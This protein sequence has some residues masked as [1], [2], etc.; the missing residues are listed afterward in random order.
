M[1]IREVNANPHEIAKCRVRERTKIACLCDTDLAHYLG[2]AVTE[3]DVVGYRMAWHEA[4]I[5]RGGMGIPRF[6]EKVA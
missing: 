6:E 3:N 5:V 2:H 4:V 1:D